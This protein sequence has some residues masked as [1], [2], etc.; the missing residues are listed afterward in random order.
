MLCKHKSIDKTQTFC[1]E[2][3]ATGVSEPKVCP[4]IIED[5]SLGQVHILKPANHNRS[6]C[7]RV[8]VIFLN[9]VIKTI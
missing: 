2:G 9:S 6:A 7:E 1:F 4:M 5:S 8:A 3:A